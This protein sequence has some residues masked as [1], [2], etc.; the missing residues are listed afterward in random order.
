MSQD[1]GVEVTPQTSECKD[2]GERL[3]WLNNDKGKRV[4]YDDRTP[5]TPHRCRVRFEKVVKEYQDFCPHCGA[6]GQKRVIFVAS[7]GANVTFQ[8]IDAI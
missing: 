1:F 6:V 8:R 7:K 2:C 3:R 4:P 5:L